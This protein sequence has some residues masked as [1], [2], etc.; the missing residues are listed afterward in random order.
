MPK[1]K[2]VRLNRWRK[3]F[4]DR[5]YFGEVWQLFEESIK[6]GPMSV[7]KVADNPK[8]LIEI[9]ILREITELAIKVGYLSKFGHRRFRYQLTRAAVKRY[10]EGELHSARNYAKELKNDLSKILEDLKYYNK[11][12]IESQKLN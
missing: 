5:S 6:N 7:Y 9:A 10:V 1:K 12:L 4:E 11:L 2:Q 8:D 3:E